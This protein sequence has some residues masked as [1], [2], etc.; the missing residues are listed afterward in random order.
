MKYFKFF[1]ITILV[2]IVI[3]AVASWQGIDSFVFAWV[4]NFMLMTSLLYM[5]E[6]FR[7]DL[8]SSYYNS[9]SWEEKGKIYEVFGVKYFR[10]LLVLVGWE[11]LNKAKNPVNKKILTLGNL[12]Y[13]TRQSEFGHSVIFVI[14]LIINL[15]V[16]IKFGF[17]KSLW[18]LVL[19]ILLNI[20]P[21][22]VQRY[23]RPR[24]RRLIKRNN[25]KSL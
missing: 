19:N 16:A 25:K 22:F 6:T 4:L 1:A 2:L 14:V 8:N 17:I 5:T 12:E 23:N 21:I 13:K 7:P 3:I 11:Q 9:K 24:L 15:I 20:Y 10:K 18:L